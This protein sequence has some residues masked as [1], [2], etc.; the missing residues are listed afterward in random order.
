LE[1]SCTVAP[2][3]GGGCAVRVFQ[4]VPGGASPTSGPGEGATSPAAHAPGAST[5]GAVNASVFTPAAVKASN[6]VAMVSAAAVGSPLASRRAALLSEL[7][8]CAR[9]RGEAR[10]EGE[11]DVAGAWSGEEAGVAGV[12]VGTTAA[13]DKAAAVGSEAEGA[14]AAGS[15]AGAGAA[16]AGKSTLGVAPAVGALAGRSASDGAARPSCASGPAGHTRVAAAAA[17]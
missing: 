15:G 4:R 2:F 13:G 6:A 3:G 16:S 8:I 10:G 11:E 5:P 9:V 7:S 1:V 17:A 12:G 14:G